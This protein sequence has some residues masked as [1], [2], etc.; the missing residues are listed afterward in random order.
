MDDYVLRI[1]DA[2]AATGG[3]LDAAASGALWPA[4]RA[5]QPSLAHTANHFF[6]QRCCSGCEG[7]IPGRRYLGALRFGNASRTSAAVVRPP[8]CLTI[9]LKKTTPCRSIKNVEG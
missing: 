5:S 9:L 2:G 4:C 8:C 6:L 7:F 1:T 3:A